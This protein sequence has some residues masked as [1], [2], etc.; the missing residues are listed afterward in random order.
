MFASGY[1]N[2]TV[3]DD[4]R[5]KFV[6]EFEKMLPLRQ[7]SLEEYERRLYRNVTPAMEEK[8]TVELIVESFKD[9]W[10]FKDIEVP[11]TLTRE[12]MFDR[13]FLVENEASEIVV[14]SP[15]RKTD[16]QTDDED[17]GL[18]GRVV[19]VTTL[20]ILGILYCRSNRRQRAE[21]FFD[22]LDIDDAKSIKASDK[23]FRAYIPYVYEISYKLMLRLY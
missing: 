20:F 7:I 4:G 15:E 3:Y 8:A 14:D 13:L 11:F 19:D 12:L 1:T 18:S 2:E 16:K 21:R 23:A 6:T 9:H 5:C 22:I 17:D 10:A